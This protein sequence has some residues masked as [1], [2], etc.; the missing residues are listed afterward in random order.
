MSRSVEDHVMFTAKHGSWKVADKLLDVDDRAKIAHFLAMVSNTVNSKIPE[1]LTG[2]VNVAGIMSLAE[3]LARGDLTKVVSSLKSPGTSKKLGDLVFEDDK[4]LKKLLVDVARAV[5]VRM[6]LSKFAPVS[7]PEGELAEVKVVFPFPDDHVNFTVKHGEW[8]VVKRLIIDDA[9]PMVE[10]AR[11]LASINETTTLKIPVYANI[12]LEGIEEWFGGLKKV[13]KS[14]IPAVIE[15]Y[16]HFQP[17]SFAS[18]E[19]EGHAR[20][21]ALR[22]ALEVIDLPLDVPAKSLEKYL[23]KK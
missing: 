3:E 23:E 5:L 4:T 8:I 11:L 12:D 18:A 2:V 20:V 16:L 9:T 10:V 15:K 21:Y 19:F 17:S 1:Y 6:T 13:K 14:E 7:Y 22:K